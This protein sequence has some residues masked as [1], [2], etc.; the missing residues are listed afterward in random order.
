[1]KINVIGVPLNLGCDREGV[2]K[3]PDTLRRNGLISTI[4]Q[5][6]HKVYDLG[7][8]YI[9]EVS[10]KNKFSSHR[11]MKY[12]D[13]IVE[14][15]NNLAEVVYA[16]IKGG[17]IPIVIGG[18]HSV[19]LGSV[20]GVKQAFDD[21]CIIWLDAHGDLNTAQTTPSG[22]VHGMILSAL[23]GIGDEAFVNLY[24]AGN[25]VKPENVFLIGT[26]SL[27]K[28][29]INVVKKTP[30]NHISM[31]SFRSLKLENV[32]ERIRETLIENGVKNVHLSIDVDSVDP[33]Y[34]PG[35]GTKVRDGFSKAEFLEL[36]DAIVKM[37]YI[38]SVDLVEFN[39]LLDVDGVTA[40]LCIDIVNSIAKRV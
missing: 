30:I 6:G 2:E 13:E 28:G 32:L 17:A 1:M 39:P 38:R 26:R 15:N 7:N 23:M 9:P 20:S 34:A 4:K 5:H 14:V 21:L 29:E 36:I 40:N 33:Y 35:T 18:D 31:D 24:S 27:D 22:N 37:G 12:H 11:K 10:E 19:G 25:K 8:Q 16:T 3:A